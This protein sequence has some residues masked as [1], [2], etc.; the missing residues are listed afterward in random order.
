MKKIID[1]HCHIY[2]PKIME[3]AVKTIGEF[4][5]IPMQERGDANALSNNEN[6]GVT[7]CIVCSVATT[8]KQVTSINNFIL[9]EVKAHPEFFGLITLHQ[10]L[11]K[12]EIKDA[13][14]FALDNNFKGIK[15]HPDF[16]KFNIDDEKVFNIYEL[17]EG[18]FPILFHTG[19]NRYTYSEPKRLCNVAKKFTDLKCIGAH[20]GG[21]QHWQDVEMYN[22]TPNVFFDT[23]S[24][25]AF[26][27]KEKCKEL[28]ELLGANRFMF[29]TDYPMWEINE[30]IARFNKIDLTEGEK[31]D[32]LFNNANRIYNLGL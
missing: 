22:E 28:I 15:L 23:S 12:Q 3:K 2:P 1:A 29:G 20:F 24:T 10:D 32:I 6:F 30:E 31:Q 4:Y 19:D 27:S 8:A 17:A 11:S 9:S 16:Q 21:Y 13:L 18:K 5:G 25:T 26:L 7:N 14:N